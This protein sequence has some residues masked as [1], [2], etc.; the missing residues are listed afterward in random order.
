ML[1]KMQAAI[2][3]EY[4][5]VVD[6]CAMAKMADNEY[7]PILRTIAEEEWTHAKHLKAILEDMGG[8]MSD[9]MKSAHDEAY[10]ALFK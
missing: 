1:E 4:E 6:Y 9:E 10:N 2:L 7:K 8:E 3:D 5:D